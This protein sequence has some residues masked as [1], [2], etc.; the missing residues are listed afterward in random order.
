MNFWTHAAMSVPDADLSVLIITDQN[1]RTMAYWDGEA[2]LYSDNEVPLSGKVTH[3]ADLGDLPTPDEC[4]SERVHH[5]REVDRLG[6]EVEEAEGR[7]N[8]KCDNCSCRKYFKENHC[9]GC[10]DMVADEALVKLAAG[11]WL[12]PVCAAKELEARNG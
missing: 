8:R 1:E 11:N 5:L 7:Y 6:K 12:C 9:S 10:G 3:W 4:S 2:W